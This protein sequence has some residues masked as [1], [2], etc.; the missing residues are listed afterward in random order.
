MGLKVMTKKKIVNRK[1]YVYDITIFEMAITFQQCM[2]E[3]K[4]WLQANIMIR[5]S[6]NNDPNFKKYRFDFDTYDSLNLILN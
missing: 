4:C 3:Q 6:A 2:K 1:R 5:Y